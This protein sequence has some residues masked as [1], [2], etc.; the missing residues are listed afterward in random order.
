MP[1]KLNLIKIE[2]IFPFFMKFFEIFGLQ[3]FNSKELKS[4]KIERNLSKIRIFVCFIRNLCTILLGIFFIWEY[5][6][7]N[8]ST[9]VNI[10]ISFVQTIQA[11]IML[12][13]LINFLLRFYL[14]SYDMKIIFLHFNKCF[15]LIQNEISSKVD[16]RKFKFM[17]HFKTFALTLMFVILFCLVF[18][19]QERFYSFL[20]ICAGFFPKYFSLLTTIHYIFLVDISNYL[21]SNIVSS[22]R[23]AYIINENDLINTN[24]SIPGKIKCIRMFEV[25]QF[26]LIKSCRKA[27]KILL[28]VNNLINKVY[29]MMIF[30]LISCYVIAITLSGYRTFVAHIE[31]KPMKDLIGEKFNKFIIII[32][33]NFIDYFVENIAIVIEFAVSLAAPVI[34]C[35]WTQSHVRQFIS[36]SFHDLKFHSFFTILQM[37]DLTNEINRLKYKFSEN[38]RFRKELIDFL[39]DL[40]YEKLSFTAYGLF[41]INLNFLFNITITIMSQLIFFV[42]FYSSDSDFIR[43]KH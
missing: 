38:E 29:G 14:S 15:I 25:E 24:V 21:I 4:D 33:I 6:K 36:S 23:E 11:F 26:K 39:D 40:R 43:K 20:N 30:L 41:E 37:N 35:A 19:V 42:Q 28:E 10:F 13:A 3:N 16:V 17:F 8:Q 7:I 5:R 32:N 1:L 31:R 9:F 34:H 12:S 22:L 18:Y 27:Y 2:D